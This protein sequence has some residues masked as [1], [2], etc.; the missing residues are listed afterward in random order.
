MERVNWQKGF[1]KI[2][3]LIAIIF[4]TISVVS[5]GT[6]IVL[7]KQQK[8]PAFTANISDV[9]YKMFYER[10]FEAEQLKQE[11]ELS[12][13]REEKSEEK[14]EEE[15]AKRVE[16]EE[17]AQ[18]EAIKRSQ[19]EAKARQEEFERKLKEQELSEKEAEEERMNTDNDGD[20][21]TY[22]QELDTG[23]SDYDNDTDDDGIIDSL[24][25]HPVGGGRNIPQTFAWS[26]GGYNWTWTESVQ[27]DWYDYYKAKPR[28]SLRSVDFIT[29][30]DPFIQKISQKIIQEETS[31]IDRV[32]LAVS[33]VQS[34][35]YVDDA[36][37]G[38]DEYPKYPVETFFEKNGDCEDSSYLAAS[39]IDAMNRGVA[40][41][42]LPGH[43]AV[44]VLMD[45]SSPGTYYKLDS[46]C[47]YY[48]E[49]T[50]DGWSSG[51]IPDKYRYTSVTLIKIPS[52]E[53]INN[54][55]PQYIKPCYSSPD[56]SGYYTDGQNTY[57]DS[58]CNNVTYCARYKDFYVKPG[59]VNFY[60]DSSCSQ[61]AVEG[62]SKSSSYPGYFT[63]GTDIY[64]DSYCIVT[65]TFCRPSPNYSDTYY[66]GYSDY[67][68][69]GCSQKV[70][71]WCYPSTYYPGY[72]YSSISYDIYIDSA[73]MVPKP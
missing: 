73:C 8:T 36:F 52:G 67:W 63:D 50:G 25:A 29:S 56:F 62:C 71:S 19:A 64:S 51:E 39:I 30:N 61:R 68:D 35:P 65:A 6:G 2:P 4:T 28:G 7:H 45:C 26:Y 44:G 60:W 17:T 23:S 27:E 59:T 14:A 32:W 9:I 54:V 49:T 46:K 43:M 15:L 37:T 47:Y 12:K 5:V 72:F 20:G 24:D 55:N 18:K 57:T 13:F 58:R 40:L 11:L 69:S 31:K 21:L 42:L 1:I 16:A 38:Y 33:F 3:L 41:I 22:R 48:V 53:T 10:G 70:Y 34:L 66:D